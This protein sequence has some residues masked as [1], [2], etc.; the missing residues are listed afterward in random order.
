MD[1]GQENGSLRQKQVEAGSRGK[2]NDKKNGGW[3]LLKITT[4]DI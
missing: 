3:K 2:E 4:E 1:G